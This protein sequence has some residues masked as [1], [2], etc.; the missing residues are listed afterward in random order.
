MIFAGKLARIGNRILGIFAAL[1]I[2][3]LGSYGGYS[4]WDTFQLYQSAYASSD[5]IRYKPSADKSPNDPTLADL[6]ALNDEVIGWITLDGTHIDYPIVQSSDDQLE[7]VNKDVYGEFSLSG[8]IFLDVNNSP[9][10]TDRYSLLYGHHM[11]NGAMFGDITE[12]EDESCF[13]SHETGTLYLLD[14]T[15]Y[16]I[17][18]FACVET[19]AMDAVV[20]NPTA[21]KDS[22]Q[23]LL[24]H[25]ENLAVQERDIGLTDSDRIIGFSTC[26]DAETNGRTIVYGR[27]E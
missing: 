25:I 22:V 23:E 26:E 1:L 19:D 6:A 8:A 12:F 17:T 15:T 4:L 13:D 14:G 18:I 24:D 2:L 9:D 5:L 21:Q 27:L 11:D 3:A 16:K 20:F 10:F 7:Y